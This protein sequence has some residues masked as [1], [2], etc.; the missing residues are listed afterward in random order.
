MGSQVA[1]HPHP[2]GSGRLKETNIWKRRSMLA[3]VLPPLPFGCATFRHKTVVLFSGPFTA[4][5]PSFLLEVKICNLM[6]VAGPGRLL[7][8]SAGSSPEQFYFHQKCSLALP[9]VQAYMKPP[10]RLPPP[11][12]LFSSNSAAQ[13]NCFLSKPLETGEEYR[14]LIIIFLSLHLPQYT[15]TFH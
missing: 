2:C 4:A 12:I 1:S 6:K 15:N 9:H 14:D 8:F 3:Q 13:Q 5:G 10:R 7:V 11:A